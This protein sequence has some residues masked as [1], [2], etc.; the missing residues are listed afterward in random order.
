[1]ALR[2]DNQPRNRP[3]RVPFSATSQKTQVDFLDEDFHKKWQ[4][5]W[6]NDQR[7][8]I[9]RAQQAGYEFV[10]AEEVIG[11]GGQDLRANTD[12]GSRVSMVVTGPV[13]GNP[14]VRAYLMKLRRDWYNEDQNDKRQKQKESQTAMLQGQAGGANV[15]NV[16]GDIRQDIKDTG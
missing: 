13:D 7:S 6:I 8:R 4:A 9:Q 5:R 12:Q 2:A 1:M 10:E 15:E 14:E 16:Y 3:K 11:I